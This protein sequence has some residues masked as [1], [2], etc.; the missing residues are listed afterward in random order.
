MSHKATLL[1]A[2]ASLALLAASAGSAS[3]AHFHGWYLGVE[4]GANWVEDF[5]ARYRRG[6][7]GS[8]T[9]SANRLNFELDSG[10]AGLATLGYGF[11]NHWRVELEGGYRHNNL[12][13]LHWRFPTPSVTSPSGDLNEWS[14]MANVAYDLILTDRLSLSLGAGAGADDAH[15]KLRTTLSSTVR[16]NDDD[17]RFAYQGLVG[18][19]YDIGDRMQVMLNYRYMRV[20]S[21]KWRG[22]ATGPDFVKINAEDLVKHTV[23]IGLRYDLWPDEPQEEP[24]AVAEPPPAPMAAPPAQSFMIFFGFN[25]CNITPEADN[26]LRQ[27]ADAAHQMGSATVQIV[28]HTDTMGSSRYN[29]KLSECRAHAA[30]SNLVGKGVPEN[31]IATSGK[32]ETELLVQTA[33]GVKEPQN[34]RATIDL[35]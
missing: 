33:D 9:T 7:V 31:M 32:G 35:Q 1:G 5:G 18:L 12:D 13:K 23:T 25:K 19:N 6:P 34:R 16:V 2:A 27:A 29:Q 30:K 22:R 8:T 24:M 3:A 26:V 28:G 17:W 21:P 11:G 15:L 20:D 10:W 14:V 4:G